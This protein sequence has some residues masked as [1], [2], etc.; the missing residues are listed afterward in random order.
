[1]DSASSST[2]ICQMRRNDA[3]AAQRRAV[4]PSSFVHC[5]RVAPRA[6]T[7]L[8]RTLSKDSVKSGFRFIGPKSVKRSFN[9]LTRVSGAKTFRYFT[10][11]LRPRF[12]WSGLRTRRRMS[13]Y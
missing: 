12:R 5:T 3:A 13:E 2:T 1:M 7:S 6:E 8:S 11:S 9:Q 10:S 4:L